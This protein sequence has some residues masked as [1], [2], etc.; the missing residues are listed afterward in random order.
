[1]TRTPPC[2]VF[3][4]CG[5]CSLQEK[6]YEEQLLLKQ[7]ELSSL[8]GK[9]I[10]LHKAPDE[11]H[12]RSRM[13]FVMMNGKI[14]LRPQGKFRE[15]V[16]VP[17]C[18]L[19]PKSANE[20]FG[21][22]RKIILESGLP[23]YNQISKTGFLQYL[24]MRYTST[25]DCMLLVTTKNPEDQQEKP[26]NELLKQLSNVAQSV[27]W[28]VNDAKSDDAASGKIKTILGEEKLIEKVNNLSY[29][30]D[31]QGFFQSNHTVAQSMAQAIAKEVKGN[32]LDLFCGVGFL[33]LAAAKNA[34]KIVGVEEFAP[35]ITRAKQNAEKNKITN[36]S[37][38]TEPALEYIKHSIIAKAQYD[39]II[40]DPPRKGL[41]MDISLALRTLGPTTLIYMSCN[42]KT[43]R[44]DLEVLFKEYEL[45]S[46]QG[47]DM[48][49]QTTH[50]EC[51]A[52]LRKK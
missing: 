13:D 32:A 26:M 39:T 45:V 2:P 49:P 52:V 27:V 20:L 40:V 41:G 14:G 22:V 48:F 7:Q 18:L 23:M 51:L 28:I 3:N 9:S 8:F 25:D 19:L 4:Q 12:Y 6:T 10:V 36:A 35:A 33:T 30:I 16:D 43:L 44:N 29:I 37:F 24:S 42:P 46:L 1:M 47:Y 50:V 17:S 34:E 31:P 15:I 5:G 21:K 11:F 38:L